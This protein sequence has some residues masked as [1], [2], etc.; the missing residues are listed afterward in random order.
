VAANVNGTERAFC[1]S[2]TAEEVWQKIEA[3]WLRPRAGRY[4]E[5]FALPLGFIPVEDDDA[6]F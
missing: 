6:P 4:G 1:G 2:M 5:F 3:F